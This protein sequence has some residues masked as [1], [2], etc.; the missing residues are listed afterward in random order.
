MKLLTE[1]LPHLL[2]YGFVGV[3]LLFGFALLSSMLGFAL[4]PIS[5]LTDT[6]CPECKGF[7]KRKLLDSEV[8]AEKEIFRT[9]DRIDQGILHSNYL[10]EPDQVIEINR[11]EQVAFVEQRIVK[12]WGCKNSLCGHMWKTE[13]VSEREG[14]L[15]DVR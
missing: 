2:F 6:Q 3:V 15:D 13:E 11:K 9:V 4:I 14:A 5:M 1:F 8:V 10:L 7:F 12:S